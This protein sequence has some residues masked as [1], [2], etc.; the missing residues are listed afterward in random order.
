MGKLKVIVICGAL[1]VDGDSFIVV[2]EANKT[3]RGKW[4]TP[5]GHTK[6]NE[7]LLT[8]T[9]REIKEETNLDIKLDG[10]LGIYQH[11]S[12]DGSNIVKI[13]FVASTITNDLKYPE[14]EIMNVK[15]MRFD[16]FLKLPLN[17]IRTTDLKTMITDYRN[18]GF[19]DLNIVKNIG[20]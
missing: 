8:T 14:N 16:D 5:G 20:F 1:I 10:L 17:E 13:I 12:I 11:K 2:Q 6:V 7:D 9:I 4:N 15:W 19:I 3:V 18:R